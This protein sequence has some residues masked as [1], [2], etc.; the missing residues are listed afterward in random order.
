M[1]DEVCSPKR[2]VAL[3]SRL[4]PAAL[5]LQNSLICTV[6]QVVE[7]LYSI[8]CFNDGKQESLVVKRATKKEIC[9]LTKQWLLPLPRPSSLASST[10]KSGPLSL[11]ER[12]GA[13]L[14]AWLLTSAPCQ[15]PITPPRIWHEKTFTSLVDLWRQLLICSMATARPPAPWSYCRSNWRRQSEIL[16]Q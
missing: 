1:F 13:G 6:V 2:D 16:P 12:L 8:D 10:N 9:M 15:L 14:R 3:S 11:I 4:R 7:L 5:V